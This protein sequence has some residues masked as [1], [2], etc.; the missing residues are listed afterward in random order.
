M[1]KDFFVRFK[2]LTIIGI[3]SIV[4]AGI[5]GIFWL[6]LASLV[7]T[8]D[9]GEISYY[10][11]MAGITT[12]ISFLGAGNVLTVYTAKEVKIQPPVY[13]IVVISS[14]I[15]AV[16]LFFMIGNVY[17][18]INVVGSILF[19]LVTNELLGVKH[20]KKWA[21]LQISQKVMMV[22][23]PIILYN[24]LGVNGVILGIGLSYFPMSIIHVVRVFKTNKIDFSLL[25][26]RICFITNSYAMDLARSLGNFDKIIIVPLLGFAILGNYQLGLQIL[27]LLGILPGVLYQYILPHD[28]TGTTNKKLKILSVFGSVI[29][30][31]LGIILAPIIIPVLFPKFTEA[32]QVIQILSIHVISNTINIIYTS[33]FLARE[34]SRTI[35][36]GSIIFVTVHISMMIILG[37]AF[38]VNGV[39][40]ALV[41]AG[42]SETIYLISADRYKR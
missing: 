4:T 31:V 42:I 3:V 20:Y 24:F 16:V 28:A 17:A 41:L 30:A 11:A 23:L 6:Y 37:K 35:L 14:L 18:S 15:A 21:I 32:V 1:N 40:A 19:A 33:Q 10:L 38:G 2:G 9:Y 22:V 36:I 7:G 34:K 25:R 29:L 26:P 39:A 13:F 27:S 5:S 8:E 12:V